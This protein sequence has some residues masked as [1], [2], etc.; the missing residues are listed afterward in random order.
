MTKAHPALRKRTQFEVR[1][2]ASKQR[3]SR[4][5]PLPNMTFRAYP[6]AVCG[7]WH[8]ATRD[9]LADNGELIKGQ[10]R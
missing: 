2:C 10:E 1:S 6:C 3:F 4:E 9:N 7:G 5:P 8:L